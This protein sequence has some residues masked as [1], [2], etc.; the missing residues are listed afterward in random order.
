MLSAC[1]YLI[2]KPLNLNTIYSLCFAGGCLRELASPLVGR[3]L[4]N[5]RCLLALSILFER[6]VD[7]AFESLH[8]LHVA[9]QRMQLLDL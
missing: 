8:L 5:D 4:P 3:Q 2:E 9:Q 7:R 6:L 1:S